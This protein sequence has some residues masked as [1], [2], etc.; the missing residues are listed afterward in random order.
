MNAATRKSQIKKHYE[1]CYRI[2]NNGPFFGQV[3]KVN[4]EWH[5]EIRQTETGTLV[6]FAGIWNTRKDAI[7]EIDSLLVWRTDD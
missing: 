4:R 5:A 2:S 7:E 6:R 3:K 1:G